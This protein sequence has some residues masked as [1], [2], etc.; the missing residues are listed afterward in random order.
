MATKKGHEGLLGQYVH[1]AIAMP[2]P[3]KKFFSRSEIQ[4]ESDIKWELN[5]RWTKSIDLLSQ[6]M[7]EAIA[8]N[9]L[10]LEVVSDQAGFAW[11]ELAGEFQALDQRNLQENQGSDERPAFIRDFK[12]V[13][14][15]VADALIKRAFAE[16]WVLIHCEVPLLNYHGAA[17]PDE[18]RIDILVYATRSIGLNGERIPR[19][20]RIYELKTSRWP[21]AKGSAEYE[22]HED[23][24]ID[25]SAKLL[26]MHKSIRSA[27]LWGLLLT[28][29]TQPEFGHQYFLVDSP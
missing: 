23:Q 7:E 14:R 12:R 24:V 25:Q 5:Q 8:G 26:R 9:P 27:E 21:I 13:A 28:V 11:H 19:G 2:F 18:I 10:L 16:Q 17:K 20:Y 1:R 4:V 3:K 29:H 22:E 15:Y 6:A